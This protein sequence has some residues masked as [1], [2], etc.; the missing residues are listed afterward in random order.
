MQ[1]ADHII[2]GSSSVPAHGAVL[3]QSVLVPQPAP[4]D[5]AL[6]DRVNTETTQRY[7]PEEKRNTR[8]LLQHRSYN[9][10]REHTKTDSEFSFQE[11]E[12]RDVLSR[13]SIDVLHPLGVAFPFFLFLQTSM[14]YRAQSLQQFLSEAFAGHLMSASPN[15][16][17]TIDLI[18]I[19]GA[20]NGNE[21]CRSMKH[22]TMPNR[23]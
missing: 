15:K 1:N 13:I 9:Y 3:C 22:A 10:A 7:I 20:F 17:T 4:I 5:C 2:V 11:R 14:F 8:S 6:P 12:R 16:N 21:P 23:A 18:S 19:L